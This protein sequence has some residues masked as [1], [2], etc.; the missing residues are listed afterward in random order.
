MS[1]S[2][3]HLEAPSNDSMSE[4]ARGQVLKADCMFD[5]LLRRSGGSVLT[6]KGQDFSFSSRVM[7]NYP[8]HVT[9]YEGP[10][11][12]EERATLVY[13]II[14]GLGQI[15]KKRGVVFDIGELDDRIL[16]A[17]DEV[18]AQ[19]LDPKQEDTVQRLLEERAALKAEQDAEDANPGLALPPLEQARVAAELAGLFA[20]ALKTQA[21]LTFDQVSP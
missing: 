14:P 21:H 18:V 17:T 8:T 9:R 10:I 11:D 15:F 5:E 6:R 20:D 7:R 1:V 16:S 2:V 4:I 12:Q 19:G 3:T 13:S